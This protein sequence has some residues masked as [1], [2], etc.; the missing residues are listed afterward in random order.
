MIST[1]FGK[2]I[3][4]IQ[5]HIRIMEIKTDISNP[6]AYIYTLTGE[7]DMYTASE[8]RNDIRSKIEEKINNFIFDAKGIEYL[9][10]SGISVFVSLFTKLRQNQKKLV[11]VGLR[12]SVMKILHYTS[13]TGILPVMDSVENALDFLKEQN[14]NQ[15]N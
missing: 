7:L 11:L 3:L 8:L 9:D 13:L 10:S 1:R 6:I 14:G 4:I 12:E 15:R 2:A 5:V